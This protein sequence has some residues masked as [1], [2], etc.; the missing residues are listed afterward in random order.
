MPFR[1]TDRYTTSFFP[2]QYDKILNRALYPVRTIRD[3][4]P[5]FCMIFVLCAPIY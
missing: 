4:S 3:L 5:K 2:I 1:W